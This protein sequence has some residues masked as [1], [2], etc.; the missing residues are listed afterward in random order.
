M[1]KIVALAV[2]LLFVFIG[3]GDK[4]D[5]GLTHTND[6]ETKT[7]NLMTIQGTY[8]LDKGEGLNFS[9]DPG[10]ADDIYVY[11]YSNE[12]NLS[13]EYT[14]VTASNSAGTDGSFARSMTIENSSTGSAVTFSIANRAD[15]TLSFKLLAWQGGYTELCDGDTTTPTTLTTGT[16]QSGHVGA[17]Y[18]SYYTFTKSGT[19]AV[20]ITLKETDTMTDA[21]ENLVWYLTNNVSSTAINVTDMDNNTSTVCKD[22]YADGNVTCTAVGL[23]NATTYRLRVEN[24]GKAAYAKYKVLVTE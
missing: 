20:T 1:G 24:N 6:Y 5:G 23:S 19:G 2:M 16:L 15:T 12:G 17:L 10:V 4:T 8:T 11:F 13:S 7:L 21:T 14:E 3:C 9:V 18:D 22:A